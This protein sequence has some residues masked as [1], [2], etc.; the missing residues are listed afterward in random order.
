MLTLLIEGGS[1]LLGA[2][3]DEK[4]VDRVWA[5]IAPLIIG[6][7]N[8]PGPVGGRGVEALAQAISLRRLQ[9]EMIDA[10]SPDETPAAQARQD[11]WIRADVEYQEEN[12]CSQES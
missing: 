8:A 6:G 9:V 3:F 7:R 12:Q 2:F 10:G 11:L 5:V 1:E 4:L